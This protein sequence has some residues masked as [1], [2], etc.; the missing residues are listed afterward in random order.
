MRPTVNSIFTSKS[1]ATVPFV[2]VPTDQM[3]H[4]Q[5]TVVSRSHHHVHI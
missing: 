2:V 4:R 5:G 1:C 3:D